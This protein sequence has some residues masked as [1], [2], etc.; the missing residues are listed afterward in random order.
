MSL[1]ERVEAL[2]T[3]PGVYLFKG[4]G[5]RVLYVGKAQN[6][7]ARVRSY[8]SG[9]DGR[10]RVPH[11]VERARDV[12]VV[13]TRSVKEALLLENELIK[14][15]K[16]P[17]NVRLR[18]DKQYLGLR[19]DPREPWPRPT[20]VRRFKRDGAHYFGPYT[21]SAS[22]K[23]AVSNLRRIFPLRS[24]REAVF[25]DYARRGRPCSAF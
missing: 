18:D 5:G 13:L 12:D 8:V 15:H 9:G 21:S 11:L 14:Q 22:L 20:P 16:P 6:L 19:L 17:F 3:G 24:C 25:R 23:D 4:E 2:P 10:V 7:R 1:A